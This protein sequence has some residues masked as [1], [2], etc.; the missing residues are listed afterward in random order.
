[1]RDTGPIRVGFV[2]HVM[3]VAGAEVLVRETI[4]RLGT[5]IEPTV[6]CLDAVGQLGEELIRQGVP[7]ICLNRKP[8]IYLI[9]EW[10]AFYADQRRP[11][12]MILEL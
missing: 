7:V 8:T 4:R 2:V 6:F 12:V 11:T 3:Q 1:M 9:A 5:A 10:G